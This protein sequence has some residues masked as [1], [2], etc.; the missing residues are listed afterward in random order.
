MESL[1]IGFGHKA[2]QG[3]DTVVR[4]IIDEFSD[5][6]NIKQYSFASAL[7]K[8]ICGKEGELC[9]IH[10]IEYDINPPYDDPLCNSIHG[11]Q[12]KLLQWYGTEYRR[13]FDKQYWIN[14]VQ[15]TIE[16]E[17]PEIALISDLRFNNE[18]EWVKQNGGYT[19]NIVRMN[20]DNI[21]MDDSAM[22]HSSECELDTATYDFKLRNYNGD[23]E[24]LR[25]EAIELFQQI[26]LAYSYESGKIL[27]GQVS[28][29]ITQ[30]WE[31]RDNPLYKEVSD[32]INGITNKDEAI[33]IITT[34][35]KKHGFTDEEVIIKPAEC[36]NANYGEIIRVN[37]LPWEKP[38]LYK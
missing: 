22:G 9:A 24:R 37:V 15:Q 14:K 20:S 33:T 38:Q 30:T 29:D 8:E 2:R 35:F 26:L 6:Y 16:D 21:K 7:K 27:E 1:I 10:G 3:K 32:A 19:V 25:K 36:V 11:K 34:V 23:L 5:R 13:G 31:Q 12:R 17:K 18:M 28:V 4:M